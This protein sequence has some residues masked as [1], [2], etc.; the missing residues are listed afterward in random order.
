MPAVQTGIPYSQPTPPQQPQPVDAEAGR[1]RQAFAMARNVLANPY[2][3][4]AA[5]DVGAAALEGAQVIFKDERGDYVLNRGELRIQ[6]ED[7]AKAA[8]NLA[9]HAAKP[10]SEQ[11]AKYILRKLTADSEL[12][13]PDKQSR[14]SS[15]HKQTA[16]V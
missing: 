13:K 11:A 7:P 10:A 3:Q 6:L 12:D 1:L 4:Q 16:T 8:K 14:Q 9:K 2:L 15:R 5:V